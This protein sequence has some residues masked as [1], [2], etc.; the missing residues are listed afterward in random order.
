MT[1][2]PVSLWT[3]NIL[4]PKTVRILDSKK[5]MFTSIDL[6]RFRW[7]EETKDSRGVTVVTSPVTI[8][9]GLLPDSTN[10]DA[11]FD[12]A[13]EILK[14]LTQNA[15]NDIDI[16]YRESVSRPLAGPVLYAP[17]DDLHPL[18]SVMDWVTT[19][20]SLPIAVLNTHDNAD[21]QGTLGF[22][23]KVGEDLYGVTARHTLFSLIRKAMKSTVMILVRPFHFP[24]PRLFL[25]GEEES[26]AF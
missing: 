25:I 4:V 14:I 10:S 22:Y 23:F 17:V 6:V 7:E 1:F 2:P 18:S 8:W 24:S 13:Q 5:I 9:I 15:I 3:D 11:A 12:S 19:P 21:M 16:A 20:L 26:C